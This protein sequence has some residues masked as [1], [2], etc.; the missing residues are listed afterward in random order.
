MINLCEKGRT[1]DDMLAAVKNCTA[2]K[3]VL[4]ND[5]PKRQKS[6]IS[7]VSKYSKQWNVDDLESWL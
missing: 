6:S 7:K 2:I 5:L 3:V 4:K 1:E